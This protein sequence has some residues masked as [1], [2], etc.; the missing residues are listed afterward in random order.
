MSGAI[1]RAAID[2]LAARVRPHY[3]RFLEGREEILLTAHSHQA[4]PDASRDGQLAAWDDAARHV[5]GKWGTVFET[6][7]PEFRRHVAKRLG[8]ERAGDIALAPNT[9]ELV[10]RLSTCFPRDG[11][12]VTTDSEFHSL[13]RQLDRLREEGLK[14]VTVEA[15]APDFAA[16]FLAAVDEHRPDWCALST[17]LFTTSRVTA[18]VDTIAAALAARST[19]LLLDAYHAFN[20]IEMNVDALPGEVFVTGGGYK[21]AQSGEG[22]CF[23][24]LPS[25]ASR[26]RPVTTGWFADFGGLED[27]ADGPVGYGD[28]GDRFFGATFDPTALYRAVY[29]YRFMDDVG[30]DVVTLRDA[31]RARTSLIVDAFDRAVGSESGVTI[32]SPRDPTERGGFVA[33]R[34]PR[35]GELCAGL[36]TRGVRTDHRG[37]LLRLGPAPYTTSDEIERAVRILAELA[38]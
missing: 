23:M 1:D 14:V 15:D 26:F 9:H 35:A 31:A 20:V 16:R 34:S 38:D 13:A 19:P 22:T 17:V 8:T 18:G 27:R 6:V 33:F 11:T 5:D 37:D 30:L 28:G 12:V 29:T 4:W 36:K 2:A 7:L 3:A 10:Y 32:A 21:Y 25:D 24:L